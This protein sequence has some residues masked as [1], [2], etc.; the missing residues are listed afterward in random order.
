MKNISTHILTKRM[1]IS[2]NPVRKRVIFQ[3]TSS[4]RGWPNIP[5]SLLRYHYFNSHPHEEDD[6]FL[7]CL[8]QPVNHFNSHPHEEDDRP[9]IGSN[10]SKCISTHILTKRMTLSQKNVM[11]GKPFQLT[12]SRRGWLQ[13]LRFPVRLQYFNSHPHEEDDQSHRLMCKGWL[14][15]QL[16]SSR[17]GWLYHSSDPGSSEHFNS[18]PHEEDDYWFAR[19]FDKPLVIST[20][21]LTKRMTKNRCGCI[22]H[23]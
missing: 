13:P 19:F 15:F 17:R 11:S 4:R 2:F 5:L 21:I 22:Y 1:T 16:T 23:L 8:I 10:P 3:L 14:G 12:S 9:I 20:H 7:F 6:C 18:H